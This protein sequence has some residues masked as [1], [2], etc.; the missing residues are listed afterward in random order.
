MKRVYVVSVRL[1]NGRKHCA[2]LWPA[3]GTGRARSGL[4]MTLIVFGHV[5]PPKTAS[6]IPLYAHDW[7]NQLPFSIQKFPRRCLQQT[8]NQRTPPNPTTTHM[9]TSK[10]NWGMP[11]IWGNVNAWHT[12]AHLVLAKTCK[13]LVPIHRMS[14]KRVILKLSTRSWAH[15]ASGNADLQ[16]PSENPFQQ[17]YSTENESSP[18]WHTQKQPGIYDR[19]KQQE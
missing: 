3:F 18:P 1:G 6:T 19:A 15:P 17:D 7:K 9:T 12:G 11:R 13:R 10:T 14:W 4:F 8:K 2:P 5:N 16:T